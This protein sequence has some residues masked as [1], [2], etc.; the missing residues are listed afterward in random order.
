MV[1]MIAEHATRKDTDVNNVLARDVK[2]SSLPRRKPHPLNLVLPPLLS[3]SDD[4][5]RPGRIVVLVCRNKTIALSVK[6]RRSGLLVS[7]M[8]GNAMSNSGVDKGLHSVQVICCAER[9][10]RSVM[11]SGGY[12]RLRSRDYLK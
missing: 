8:S 10:P 1:E 3:Q 6:Q 5:T 4:V 12:F 9:T 2:D 11:Y 7:V